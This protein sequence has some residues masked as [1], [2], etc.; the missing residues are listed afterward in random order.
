MAFAWVQQLR[1]QL[2]KVAPHPRFNR[3][4]HMRK[5]I[6]TNS[7]VSL[8]YN[9]C[10]LHVPPV[11]HCPNFHLNPGP[12]KLVKFKQKKLALLA[13]AAAAAA[14]AAVPLLLRIMAP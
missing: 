4:K 2:V 7:C 3:F 5:L 6:T 10:R 1:Q 11:V 14:A 12:T 8:L 9:A 13:A